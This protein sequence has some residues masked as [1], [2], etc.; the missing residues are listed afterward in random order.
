MNIDLTDVTLHIDETLDASRLTSIEDG[1]RGLDGVVSVSHLENRPHLK[2]VAFNPAKLN[3]RAVL[4]Q[5]IAHG[6]H[7]ELIGL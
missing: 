5:V 3:A 7:A 4:A 6:V 1:L 2:I